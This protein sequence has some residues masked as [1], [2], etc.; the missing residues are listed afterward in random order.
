MH[1]NAAS[2]YSCAGVKAE[3]ADT[4]IVH[5]DYEP[6]ACPRPRRPEAAVPEFLFPLSCKHSHASH[7]GSSQ[8]L[9]MI[10]RKNDEGRESISTGC[11]PSCYCGSPPRRLENPLIHDVQFVQQTEIVSPLTLSKL[12]NRSINQLHFGSSSPLLHEM[13]EPEHSQLNKHKPE[14]HKRRKSINLIRLSVSSHRPL[15]VRS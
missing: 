5:G 13:K 7:Q 15:S 3:L 2:S 11:P 6:P 1:R 8:V 4:R 12:S 9:D 10:S 14:Q